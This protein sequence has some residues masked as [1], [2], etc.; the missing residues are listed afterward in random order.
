MSGK[1]KFII[2]LLCGVACA[3]PVYHAAAQTMAPIATDSRI[4]TFVYS[5][6]EVYRLVLHYGYQSHIQLD[7]NEEI[8][9]ISVGDPYAWKV[10]PLDYRIFVKPLEQSAYTN[11]TIITDKHT[12]QFDLQSKEPDENVD[13]DLVYQVRFFYPDANFDAPN[14]PQGQPGQAPFSSPMPSAMSGMPRSSMSSPMMPGTA[15]MG[16]DSMMGSYALPPEALESPSSM[17]PAPFPQAPQF[18]P[19]PQNVSVTV[20]PMP[21]TGMPMGSAYSSKYNFDYTLTG[22]NSI[23]PDRV[24][25][26][27]TKTYFVF[28]NNNASVP[29]V[30]AVREKDTEIALPH[31]MVGNFVAV[32]AVEKKF[33]LRLGQDVVFV[34]NERANLANGK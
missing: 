2:P 32:D 29:Y 11:M 21:E 4:K 19:M 30:A 25:D 5:E 24:F 22:P 27:G 17:P 20:P 3:F 18:A 15:G 1:N 14:S 13:E 12:Y 7:K 16:G 6:N 8:Q 26:D 9:A 33:S 28:P 34:Y 31:Y 10:T 23:A